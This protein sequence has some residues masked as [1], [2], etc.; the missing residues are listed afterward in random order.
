MSVINTERLALRPL[1]NEDVDLLFQL[2]GSWPVIQWLS[3]PP[4]PY[5]RAD[6]Q[7]HVAG[8]LAATAPD[9]EVFRVITCNGTPIGGLSTRRRPASHLQSGAGPN[10][11][12]WLGQA[13]WG[14]G[15]MTEAAAALIRHIFATC[16]TEAIYSG[17]FAGNMA[18]LAVQSKLGFVAVGQT[19]LHSNPQNTLLPHVNTLLTRPAL[20]APNPRKIA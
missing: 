20:T 7:R 17:A 3:N 19:M 16:D 6:M 8:L 15:Y 14:K 5:A 4:W 12:Y 13:H 1:T 2:F 11:G 10:I 18:S 9:R